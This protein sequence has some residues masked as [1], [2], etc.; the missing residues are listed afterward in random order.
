MRHRFEDERAFLIPVPSLTVASAWELGTVT[1]HPSTEAARLTASTTSG[2]VG[3]LER[4]TLAALAAG[5]IVE[6]SAASPELA[7]EAARGAIDVLRVFSRWYTRNCALVPD[8]G[9]VSPDSME[10]IRYLVADGT[11][12]GFHMVERPYGFELSADAQGAWASEP[13][14]AAVANAI[15]MPAS[16]LSEGLRR[17]CIGTRLMARALSEPTAAVQLVGFMTALGGPR[18]ACRRRPPSH[19]PV[20]RSL[21][22]LTLTPPAA[23]PDPAPDRARRAPSRRRRAAC[24]GTSPS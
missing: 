11:G 17:A 23:C 5:S 20:L 21:A 18:R 10:P 24:A 6:V 19:H 4:D 3:S 12:A 8:F 15:S 9:L 14:F 2:E 22:A 13:A 7:I 16:E 1:I